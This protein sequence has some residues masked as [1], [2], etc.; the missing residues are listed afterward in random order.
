MIIRKIRLTEYEYQP[1]INFVAGATEPDIQFVLTDYDIPAGAEARAYVRRFDGTFEYTVA[2]IDGNTVTVEPTSS[3]FSVRGEGAI[4]ITLYAG[5]EVLKNF[6]VPVFVHADLA[7]ESAE[8][9]SDVTGVF[10]AAEEAALEDFQERAEEK[11]AEVIESIPADYT[12]LSAEV[13]GIKQDLTELGD[14]PSIKESDAEGVDIDVSDENGN[15][16]ARFG[17]GHIETKYFNSRKQMTVVSTDVD[18]VDVDF[19]DEAGNVIVRFGGGQIKTKNFDSRDIS[20]LL[21]YKGLKYAAIGDSIT[22]GYIPRNYDGY[23]GQLDSFAKITAQALGM[24]FYNYGITGSTLA[25]HETRDPMSRRYTDLPDSADLITVMGGTNDIRNGISL[26]Q[27]SDRTDATF[28]GALHVILGGLYRKYF[29]NQGTTIGKSKKIV[30][31]TPI[32]LLDTSAST[33]G[34]DGTLVDMTAWVSAVKEVAAY[35]SFPVMDFYNLSMINPHI[36]ETVQ[37]TESGYTGLYNPY[38]TDGTHPTQE[39]AYIMADAFIGFL[40]TLM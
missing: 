28:Y 14:V 32:K 29:I 2:T 4:Q 24:T 26:G 40:K 10:R 13:T 19:T 23:P 38:I 18:E 7:D 35:Y 8:Q 39:G 22:Y 12:E 21:R 20:S 3:M 27:M 33:L 11:A 9:G 16:L 5:E 31:C 17:E 36:A 6:S 30:V 34:G 15:V 1:P 37:G 25:Y